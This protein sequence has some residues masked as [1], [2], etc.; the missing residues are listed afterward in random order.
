MSP[1]TRFDNNSG[2]R[3]QEHMIAIYL[4]TRNRLIGWTIAHI[5]ALNRAAVE[6][7]TA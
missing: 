3:P 4:N 5:G 1:Y 2:D 6:P 7:R